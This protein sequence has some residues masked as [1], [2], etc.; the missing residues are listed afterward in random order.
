MRLLKWACP[1]NSERE[2]L[3]VERIVDL[4]EPTLTTSGKEERGKGRV[5]SKEK[6]EG[7]R[8]RRRVREGERAC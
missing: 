2:A 3:D 5:E 4:R 1:F 8:G 6:S 7:E